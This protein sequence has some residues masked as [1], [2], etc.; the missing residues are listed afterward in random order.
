MAWMGTLT[1]CTDG[2]SV[3]GRNTITNRCQTGS[4]LNLQQIVCLQEV[5][6]RIDD[7]GT[8]CIVVTAAA[9]ELHTPVDTGPPG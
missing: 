1:A 4:N 5:E 9:R 6:D 8:A 7:A 3:T 2:C